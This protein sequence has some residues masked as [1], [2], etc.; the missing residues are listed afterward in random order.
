[1]LESWHQASSR[2]IKWCFLKFPKWLQGH[3]VISKASQISTCWSD[4][5]T[6]YRESWPLGPA[7]SLLQTPAQVFELLCFVRELIFLHDDLRSLKWDIKNNFF[8]PTAKE[9]SA[10]SM[11][12]WCWLDPLLTWEEAAS[13]KGGWAGCWCCLGLRLWGQW[14]PSL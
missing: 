14:C 2:C 9:E 11:T 7:R 5:H 3:Y 4:R 10:L 13:G 12:G 8:L 1:M 6:W